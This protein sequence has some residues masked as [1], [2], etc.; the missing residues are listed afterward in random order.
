MAWQG[1]RLRQIGLVLVAVLGGLLLLVLIVPDAYSEFVANI[2]RVRVLRG[3]DLPAFEGSLDEVAWDSGWWGLCS[4]EGGAGPVPKSLS[5][6]ALEF[7]AL[8]S[9]DRGDYVTAQALLQSLADLDLADDEP[10]ALAYLAALDMDW[11]EAAQAY[12]PQPTSRH[13]RWWGTVF[14]LAA[15]NLTF[16][17]ELDKAS[18]LYRHADAAYGVH[19][20][21]LGL[22]LVECL[23]QR[24][25]ALE[26][27]DAYRRALVVMPPQEALDHVPRFDELRL[28]GLRAWHELDPENGQ[29]RHWLAF[30]EDEDRRETVGS[31]ALYG[32]PAPQ[33]SLELDLG[34][35]RTLLGFDYHVEDLETGPFMEVDFY[36][37]EGQGEQTSY[38]RVR[39]TVLN[40]APNGA[41]AW[42]AVPDGVRPVGWHGLVYS[43]DLAALARE[44]MTPGEIWQ[45]L[46][47]GRIGMSFGLQGVTAPLNLKE[48]VYIQGGRAFP[49]GDASLSLGRTW[50]GAKDRYNYSYVGGGRQPDQ[51]QSM[52]GAWQPAAGADS[53]AVWLMA[54]YTSRGCFR[55]LYLFSP[56]VE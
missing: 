28:E 51:A 18:E 7:T 32:E 11:I 4:A 36:L 3:L 43:H 22:G 40:Q 15:Q 26:A 55:D 5:D 44:E 10:N 39:D 35:G 13:E 27:W 25:R 41:F 38:R 56:L 29:I 23:V 52:V 46:D 54:H 49:V 9:L 8:A 50:F 1:K 48:G 42:D 21:Y 37:R 16:E 34:D 24:G 2:E 53:A 30:Y 47:A 33:L 14:Y 19:G 17:G 20:P 45:C 31:Y 6:R 12:E